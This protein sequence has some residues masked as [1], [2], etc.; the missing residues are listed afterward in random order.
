ML[1]DFIVQ[2][3]SQKVGQKVKWMASYSLEEEDF[4]KQYQS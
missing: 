1:K 2:N 3:F 4:P